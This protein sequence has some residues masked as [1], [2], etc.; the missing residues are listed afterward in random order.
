MSEMRPRRP[1]ATRVVL[2]LSIVVNLFLLAVIGGHVLRTRA[3]AAY[4]ESPVL[5]RLASLEQR[6][7]PDD[8]ARFRA[9]LMHDAPGFMPE[10][11]EL[12]AAR[13]RVEQA[14]LAEPFDK[15]AV[16]AAIAAWR[17]DWNRFVPD[18]TGPLVDALAAIS[19][20]GRHVM[21]DSERGRR[22]VGVGRSQP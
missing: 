13:R 7:P 18:F 1:T 21:V 3:M 22:S 16:T 4:M 12:A 19:S 6:L 14:V 8:A 10:A 9:V 20:A 11:S 15:E 2:V 17:A 5:A